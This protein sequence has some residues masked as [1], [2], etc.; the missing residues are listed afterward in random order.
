MVLPG[1]LAG[2]YIATTIV[3]SLLPA[4]IQFSTGQLTT[5]Y[6]VGILS[7]EIPDIDLLLFYF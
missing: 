6:I 3:L 1:H 7:G 2:G 4:S 5:L